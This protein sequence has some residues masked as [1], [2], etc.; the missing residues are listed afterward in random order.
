MTPSTLTSKIDLVWV[1]APKPPPKIPGCTLAAPLNTPI[2]PSDTLRIP[3]GY[4][5][6]TLRMPFGYPSEWL[7]TSYQPPP[8]RRHRL[9]QTQ[10]SGAQC[11]ASPGR[12]T[13]RNPKRSNGV[14][15]YWDPSTPPLEHSITPGSRIFHGVRSSESEF[16]RA[17]EPF[18][19]V[20]VLVL[21]LGF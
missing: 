19:L 11:G 17:Y 14:L 18:L 13:E 8:G 3:F 12:G 7:Y 16:G 4:P 2:S 9:R 6:D 21:V 20:V 10:T 15:E 5:S 1:T